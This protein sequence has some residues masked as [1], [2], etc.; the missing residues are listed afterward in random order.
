M[1]EHLRCTNVRDVNALCHNYDL[2]NNVI[3]QLV[4][5]VNTKSNNN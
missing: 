4:Q 1:F 5:T 2:V 3:K